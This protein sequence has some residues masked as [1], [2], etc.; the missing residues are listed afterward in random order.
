MN[1]NWVDERG[2]KEGI[3]QIRLERRSFCDRTGN[4]RR[5][6]RRER[7][8]KQETRPVGVIL[9]AKIPITDK[10]IRCFAFLLPVREA[11]AKD[12]ERYRPDARVQDVFD[13][14]ILGIFRSHRPGA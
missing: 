7:P 13:Q 6:C 2:E 9:Q 14:N 10:F 8:L 5:C 11:V 4:N 3:A 12:E 1:D